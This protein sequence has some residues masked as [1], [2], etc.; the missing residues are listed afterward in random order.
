MSGV[1]KVTD[2]I[3]NWFGLAGLMLGLYSGF[4]TRDEYFYPST[5]RLDEISQGFYVR[6][7]ILNEDKVKYQKEL[8]E[9]KK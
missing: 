3:S 2:V 6:Q 5:E 1:R 8:D 9:L 7:E 4:Q